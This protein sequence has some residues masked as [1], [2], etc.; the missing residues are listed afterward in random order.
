MIL[1]FV[2]RL[3]VK[4]SG[5]HNNLYRYE[6]INKKKDEAEFNNFKKEL[7]DKK[8][9]C[10]VVHGYTDAPVLF[11]KGRKIINDSKKELVLIVFCFD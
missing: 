11:K 6:E 8:Y 3:V 5:I 2:N 7:K 1:T 4:K 9:V 10:F